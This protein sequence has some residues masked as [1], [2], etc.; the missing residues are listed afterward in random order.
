[1]KKFVIITLIF[2]MAAGAVFAQTAD[3][4]SVNAWGRGVFAPLVVEGKEKVAG[5]ADKIK[6][7]GKDASY[8]QPEWDSEN[9]VWKAPKLNPPTAGYEADNTAIARSGAGVTWGGPRART[10]FRINGNAEFVG[11]Q[12]QL[13]GEDASINDNQYIWAKP[14][15][16][17]ILKLYVG[18]FDVD[19]LRGKVDT[20]TGF[21]N[22]VVGDLSADAI[23]HRFRAG[24]GDP[25]NAP[26]SPNG[27]MLSSEPIE[28]L[29]IGFRVN[30]AL[31][32]WGGPSSGTKAMDAFRYMQAGFGYEIAD[33]G[34]IRAQWIGGWF[35]TSVD[36]KTVGE[37]MG[38]GKYDI[39]PFGQ[40]ARIEAAFALTAIDGLLVD[41]GGKF[42]LP[43][44]YKDGGKTSNGV[45]VNVGARF[46]MEAFQIVGQIGVN[47]LGSYARGDKDDKSTNG[48]GGMEYKDGKFKLTPGLAVNLI[49]TFD[50]EAFTVGASLGLRMGNGNGKGPDGKKPEADYKM[51]WTQFGFGAFAQKGLGSGNVK[52]GLAYTTAP[53]IKVKEADS[54]G[55][56]GRGVFSIPIILEYA[57]F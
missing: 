33:I 40:P 35:G 32:N 52:A 22:F 3:G 13:S 19:N 17:D 42:W 41:L 48:F 5:K 37:D 44:A 31:W 36:P 4:I 21:E 50:L 20:D 53:I 11:F 8:D 29:F 9:G 1:M 23:F 49:P 24:G 12:V 15:S 7:E 57:F 16:N 45:D 30:G 27:Y 26:D 34:H 28:G 55:A 51:S 56:Y 47:G 10:D 25:N 38:K 43:Y 18:H 39:G 2:A 54:S 46:R 6:V 14:F